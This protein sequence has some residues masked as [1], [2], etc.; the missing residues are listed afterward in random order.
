M[1]AVAL[2]WV[3]EHDCEVPVVLMHFAVFVA[4]SAA[5][6]CTTAQLELAHWKTF[7]PAPEAT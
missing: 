2:V 7:L 3:I 1:F 4:R 6:A 5:E